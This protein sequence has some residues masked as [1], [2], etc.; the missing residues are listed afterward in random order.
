MHTPLGSPGPVSAMG[1]ATNIVGYVQN[2]LEQVEASKLILAV[3]YYGY[4][5]PQDGSSDAGV[6]ILPYAEIA[7]ASGNIQLSWNETSETPFYVYKE[8]N[9]TARVV[10]FDNVRSLGIK[11]DFIN[12]K[13]LKGVGI[14]ALGYDGKNQDLQKLLIDKFINL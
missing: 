14:W 4:D 12:R 2:Y 9:G 7:E 1:G 3:P 11:Y 6:K 13:D 5:W 10:H 8:T